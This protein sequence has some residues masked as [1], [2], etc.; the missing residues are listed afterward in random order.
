[1]EA[2]AN[3]SYRLL[4]VAG[5]PSGDALA[6]GL[7]GALREVAP[8][9]RFEIFGGTGL[10]MRLAGVESIVD[11]D[12]LAITG[13]LEEARALHRFWRAFGKLRHA[14]IDRKPD[15]VI[16]VDWPDF[17]LRLAR[18][19]HRRGIKVIYYVSPQLWAWRSYRVRNIRRDVDLLLTILP[20][21]A[22]WYKQREVTHVEFVGH[23]LAGEVKPGF[24]RE[25]FCLKHGL[26]S[27]LP[28]VALL[29]GSRL[30]ELERNL[31]VMLEAGALLSKDHPAAQFV[32]PLASNRSTSEAN[33]L[34]QISKRNGTR[35]I[36]V[37]RLVEHETHETLAVADVA[38]VASGTATLEAALAGVPFVIV[39]KE[40][41]INW[42][43]L[44]SLIHTEHYG[45]INL[46][47]GKRLVPELMQNEFTAER[48]AS[49][50]TILLDKD[51]NEEM[52]SKLREASSLLGP[53]GASK[54]A[55]EAVLRAI[56]KW[57]AAA[58][59]AAG[60]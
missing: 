27:K 58:G 52:R 54:R 33:P 11:T 20:F 2:E 21:E 42:Y 60:S 10:K 36:E 19:F 9:G 55:A 3:K 49:E 26:D 7:V 23:P 44:G 5:E 22:D 38:A 57:K 40:S 13:L 47:A 4:I 12:Q 32:V 15:A 39:Y 8:D 35:P 45:L 28:I 48:L 56:R 18:S 43:L 14:G 50:L 6:A 17:N 16:L 25:E 24:G 34:I 41:L 30:K 29:P 46:I 37:L 53:A 59:K 31:P 51:R 1:M